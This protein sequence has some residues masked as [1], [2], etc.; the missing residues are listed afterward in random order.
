M[1]SK[2]LFL[3]CNAHL[4]PVWLWEWE[5]GAAEALSTFRTAVQLCEEFEEFVFNHNEAVLYKWVEDYEPD[6]FTKINKL[7]KKRKWHIMGGW[8]LQPD[9]NLPSG[10][11]LVRQILVGKRY[12]REKF[13]T[14][15]KTAINLDPFGH[16]RGLVQIL[17]K[18]GYSSYL[19]C[20]PDQ[21]ELELPGDD[22]IW[23]GYDG[24]EILAHRSRYHYNS[25][26][27]KA[28][29]KVKNWMAEN[30]DQKT[31]MLLWGIGDHGGGPSRIDLEQLRGLM[32]EKSVW[33][34][35]HAIPEDYFRVLSH[36]KDRLPH[37]DQDM[38]PWAVGCYTTMALVKQRHRQL[39]N[40]YFLTEKMVTQAA[41]QGLMDY[42][43]KELCRA[44]EDLLFCEFHDILPGSSI[45]QGEVY[46]LQ[47]MDHGL[48]ILSRLKAK[49]FFALLSGQ[50][51]AGEEEFPIF[52]YNPHPHRVK[53]M[54]VC[55][56]QPYEPKEDRNITYVPEIA[57][58]DGRIIPSQL[59]KESS[60]IAVDWRK[61]VVFQAE[62]KPGQ[63][64]RFSC[65]LKDVELGSKK[66]EQK[67]ISLVFQ[68]GNKEV[69]VNRKTGLM[70]RYRINGIDFLN[71]QSFRSLAVE[72]YPD[73]WGMLVRGFRN[74]K[75]R[76]TLMTKTESARFAGISASELEPVRIIED[77][78]VRTVI[79]ALF[80]YNNSGICQRYKIPKKGSEFEVEVRVFW[81]EKDCMLKFSV[82]T[83]FQKGSCK[84]QVAYGVEDFKRVGEELV[85]QKWVAAVSSDKKY[86]LTVINNGTYGFDFARGEVRLSLL[87]PAGYAAHP[88]GE[89]IPL[90][91]Q[92][93]FEPRIDLGMRV[94]RFWINGGRTAGRLKRIDREAL[95][96]N[97]KATVLSCFP[98]GKGKKTNPAVLLND[99]VVQVTTLKI[100]EEKNWILIRLFNPTGKK[101]KTNINIPFLNSLFE[102]SIGGFEI[103]T[104]AVALRTKEVFEVDLME[105][106]IIP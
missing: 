29:E 86:T 16:T 88:V 60:N 35:R 59:E 97:E 76:F 51:K 105:R 18:S 77:G 9:C 68:S 101:R 21:K 92:D 55:E 33:K 14:E 91:P 28:K 82:P 41:L 5:E 32:A 8:Y 1:S 53:E 99:S 106:R 104:M 90:V 64:N 75:G 3:I 70:D 19:F 85:A 10:E 40:S 46:A 38:N 93:R 4:D 2:T 31:G 39:E 100:A 54:I 102:V 15:P 26:K 47:R 65:K 12:F 98:S 44:L 94:F 79:E 23:V 80:K 43:R 34:V 24:S 13:G 27:G 73:P 72:D 74:V 63:M 42:P 56:F 52:V 66:K 103:K 25:Q 30:P 96:K 78:P 36:R 22:F 6:L 50:Q 48:E 89:G 17:K 57:D 81:C 58:T 11:S 84:G 69:I 49:A 61:R 71:S 87:R 7:I 67:K 20:R 95:I 62:L 45:S 37:Y 83:L